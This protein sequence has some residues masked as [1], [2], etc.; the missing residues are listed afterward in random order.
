LVVKAT[1]AR[2]MVPQLYLHRGG[3]LH[4]CAGELEA[5]S[6]HGS[7]GSVGL[8]FLEGSTRRRCLLSLGFCPPASSS[9]LRS[10]QRRHGAWEVMYRS[11][12]GA[13]RRQA[14]EAGLADAGCVEA[15]GRRGGFPSTLSIGSGGVA[16]R[17]ST[18]FSPAD[19]PQRRQ[20]RRARWVRFEVHKAAVSAR[21][22]LRVL[23]SGL[24]LLPLRRLRRRRLQEVHDGVLHRDLQGLFVIFCF[25][26]V[27]CAKCRHSWCSGVF[28]MF[29]RCNQLL[30]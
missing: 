29:L 6:T 18:G 10:L 1:P 28:V 15:G 17:M 23:V 12:A 25:R 2:I 19:V 26:K 13:S 20:S 4:V 27:F 9:W 8:G 5:K 30:L 3:A 11:G 24:H 14:P 7:G 22:L 16:T 21:V